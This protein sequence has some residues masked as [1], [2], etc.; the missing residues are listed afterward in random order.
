M[1]I[2]Q[3]YFN[4]G[5]ENFNTYSQWFDKR[6]TQLK[7]KSYRCSINK[8]DHLHSTELFKFAAE[9]NI[10]I[11]PLA[12]FE[13]LIKK[14]EE[15]EI[16]QLTLRCALR[17]NGLNGKPSNF[18][19]VL[20]SSLFKEFRGHY[21][22]IQD[23]SGIFQ[24]IGN[25]EYLCGE[26][27]WPIIDFS[28]PPGSS[29]FKSFNFPRDLYIEDNFDEDG[30]LIVTKKDFEL[31]KLLLKHSAGKDTHYKLTGKSFYK[32]HG[33]CEICHVNY[34]AYSEHILTKKHVFYMKDEE[35]FKPLDMLIKRIK[36]A[37]IQNSRILYSTESKLKNV[38]AFQYSS[39]VDSECSS[40]FAE[41]MRN[42][43]SAKGN[44]FHEVMKGLKDC[45]V[46]SN[47]SVKSFAK[48]MQSSLQSFMDKM[49]DNS[50]PL[51]QLQLQPDALDDTYNESVISSSDGCEE[52]DAATEDAKKLCFIENPKI[53]EKSLLKMG[54]KDQFFDDSRTKE[55]SSISDLTELAELENAY[56][57]DEQSCFNT[58][59][60]KGNAVLQLVTAPQGLPDDTNAIELKSDASN[61]FSSVN[62]NTTSY[63]QVDAGM[64]TELKNDAMETNQIVAIPVHLQNQSVSDSAMQDE[65]VISS[66]KNNPESQQSAS[67]LLESSSIFF[68]PQ[69]EAMPDIPKAVDEEESSLH[70]ALNTSVEDITI[71]NTLLKTT[72]KSDIFCNVNFSEAES[73]LSRK[74]EESTNIPADS[75][76]VQVPETETH[77][78]EGKVQKQQNE[79]EEINLSQKTNST[80]NTI[81]TGINSVTVEEAKLS[82]GHF[83]FVKDMPQC[84][85]TTSFKSSGLHEGT[86]IK[87]N[88][89]EDLINIY[90]T[91]VDI[92]NMESSDENTNLSID[93]ENEKLSTKTN[94]CASEIAE[95]FDCK[96]CHEKFT[97]H[98]QI[99]VHNEKHHPINDIIPKVLTS[100][101]RKTS[102][103]KND[104]FL[105]NQ[106]YIDESNDKF[107]EDCVKKLTLFEAN[108]IKS[109][110]DSKILSDISDLMISSSRS[111][112]SDTTFK[113]KEFS[114]PKNDGFSNFPL[115]ESDSYFRISNLKKT[116]TD[117]KSEKVGVKKRKHLIEY[118]LT[119]SLKNTENTEELIKEHYVNKEN[120]ENFSILKNNNSMTDKESCDG[121]VPS[122]HNC[123]KLKF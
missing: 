7:F 108:T 122:I 12:K 112:F 115:I 38:H 39:D 10:K 90:D 92:C 95:D 55:E 47:M 59:S 114:N 118:E 17:L 54:E 74:N 111:N 88:L 40:D 4:K 30:E 101:V 37:P 84:E 96:F 1:R 14:L 33:Y 51:H 68:L 52:D 43:P 77:F 87:E 49:P 64:T 66:L 67:K 73:L 25:K 16:P 100:S 5:D 18:H 86:E 60:E 104:Y 9:N 120:D 99:K 82:A 44:M 34:N 79:S 113:K 123:K 117:F 63:R 94:R 109:K 2:P 91:E 58:S 110:R 70:I 19:N 98:S 3:G 23:S 45:P 62:M 105:N 83:A 20:K 80:E 31:N 85:E 26:T 75:T 42:D 81:K 48:A 41:Y 119:T 27:Y 57:I 102:R 32:K 13:A 76:T 116:D 28:S 6:L 93:Q 53:D 21:L 36:R 11:W 50:H 46:H 22:L 24:P 103:N 97:T 65:K 89:A 107:P 56:E 71:G 8:E 121:N 72:N 69:K 61:T 35:K 29:A 78:E 106:E 15:V